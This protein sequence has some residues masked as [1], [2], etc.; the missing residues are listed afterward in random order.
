MYVCV[1]VCM[2]VIVG[3]GTVLDML[4]DH[5]VQLYSTAP[6]SA[7]RHLPA[8]LTSQPGRPTPAERRNTETQ[9]Q[10]GRAAANGLVEDLGVWLS[11]VTSHTTD[12]RSDLPIAVL[13]RLGNNLLLYS[14]RWSLVTVAARIADTLQDVELRDR[15]GGGGGS[16]GATTVRMSSGGATAG[17]SRRANAAAATAAS[18]DNGA[19]QQSAWFVRAA[20]GRVVPVDGRGAVARPAGSAPTRVAYEDTLLHAAASTGEPGVMALVLRCVGLPVCCHCCHSAV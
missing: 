11:H 3:I 4:E 19:A 20:A 7:T 16:V 14:V 5:Y 2:H 8:S 12:N 13:A 18:G 10:S 1:C 15:S 9:K 6:R 17:P